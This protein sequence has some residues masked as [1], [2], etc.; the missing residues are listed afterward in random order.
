VSGGYPSGSNDPNAVLIEQIADLRRHIAEL[1]RPTGTSVA[2]LVA[3]VQAAL[4]NID[5]TVQAAI[6]ENSYTRAQI[7]S[8]VA[9]PGDISPGNVT[10]SGTGVFP[11]G[12]K[13]LG[14]YNLLLTHAYRVQYI[15]GDDG[16]MG[17][18][19]SSRRFKQDI[20]TA[21]DV[22][23]A[24]LAIRVVNF[25]YI[26]A[27]QDLGDEAAVEWGVIAE[28]L[29]DL[30]LTWAVDY[31][32]EGLPFGVKYERLMLAVIPVM[33]DHEDRLRAAGL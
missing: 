21:P 29:H 26:Q 30:G 4:A 6:Q 13:S 16:S 8:K 32:D 14:V 33:Q 25:R 9:S 5:A 19:P 27:V 10:S 31:D 24:A 1:A 22:K 23:E 3:Q 28:E 20:V 17:Y 11:V 2:S 7:D 18:V 12:V 15:T